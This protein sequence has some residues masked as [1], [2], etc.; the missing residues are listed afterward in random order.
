MTIELWHCSNARSFR[1]L[2]TLEEIGLPYQL[3]MLNFPPRVN[4]KEFF[5]ENPLGTIP[6]LRDGTTELT[7]SCAMVQYLGDRYGDGQVNRRA[8]H[9]EYGAYV[10]WLHHGEATLTF[11]QTLILRYGHFEPDERKLPQAAA[12]YTQWFLARLRLAEAVLSDGRSYLLT[13]GF[14]LADIAVGYA[15]QLAIT[16]GLRNDL[17]PH[18]AAWFDRLAKRP[19][20]IRSQSIERDAHLNAGY[21]PKKSILDT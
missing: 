15:I 18:I 8:D 14:S 6:F 4:H 2:W 3:H 9:P 12:D 11:P 20:F 7:E 10:N 19:A 5:Q 16:I 1:V 17:P 13:S 21:P